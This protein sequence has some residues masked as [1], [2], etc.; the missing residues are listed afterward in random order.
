MYNAQYAPQWINDRVELTS[1]KVILCT[2]SSHSFL[3]EE[4]LV[5]VC[6]L[7]CLAAEFV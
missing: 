6:I 3:F 7:M 1:N 5:L 4:V 2:L